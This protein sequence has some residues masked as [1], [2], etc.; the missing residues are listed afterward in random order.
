[1]ITIFNLIGGF[2]GCVPTGGEIT[3]RVEKRTA[4]QAVIN[5]IEFEWS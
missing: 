1:M 5:A 2:G 4:G 3:I